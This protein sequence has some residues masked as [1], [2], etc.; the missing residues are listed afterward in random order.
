MQGEGV[1]QDP[2]VPFVSIATITR[3]TGTWTK[4]ELI[5]TLAARAEFTSHFIGADNAARGLFG[6]L[7]ADL[8]VA[9]TAL[10][11]GLLGDRHLDPWCAPE[12]ATRSRRRIL[13]RMRDD[14][15]IDDATYQ[16]ANVTELGLTTPPPSHQPC[17]G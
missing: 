10:V 17:D 6:R 14:G 12:A 1:W 11:A 13:E 8:T 4:A 9:Q 3:V 2:R 7:P 5:D 16:S 15:V